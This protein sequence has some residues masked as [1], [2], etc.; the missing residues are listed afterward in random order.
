MQMKWTWEKAVSR[1]KVD[2]SNKLKW[3]STHPVAT[4]W[5]LLY[6]MSRHTLLPNRKLR[7]QNNEHKNLKKKKTAN[8]I[9]EKKLA[10]VHFSVC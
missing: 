4:V 8:P 7:V 3:Q 5:F 1:Q 9:E 10:V 6:K 2:D